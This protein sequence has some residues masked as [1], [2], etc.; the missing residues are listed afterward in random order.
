LE[1]E[2]PP[3]TSR[4]SAAMLARLAGVNISRVRAWQ[5]RGWIVPVTETMRLAAFDFTELTVARQL[6]VLERA[7]AT[8][9]LLDRKLAEIHRR[10][11][12]VG[13]PLAELSLVLDGRKLLV[14]RGAELLEA[15]G[16][17]LLDFEAAADD[18]PRDPPPQILSSTLFLSRRPLVGGEEATPE[19]FAAWAA[20]QEE[21]GDLKLAAELYRVAMA[22][23]GPRPEWCFQLA[24]TLYRA[25]DLAA[26]RERYFIAIELDEDYVEARANLGCVLLDLGEKELAV[27]AFQG[28]LASFA[29]YA[30]AHYHLARTLDELGQCQS[31]TEHWSRFLDLAPDSPWADEARERLAP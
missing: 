22:A 24:E 8:L 23:G 19:Q 28:A 31:A 9:R 2:A 12:D 25:G 4:Y 5:R 21:A 13:R 14:R 20:E 1:T 30:D 6:A 29:D 10:W 26:A 18:V 3:A 27:A 16:Q 7:G 11:P 15:G 17:L